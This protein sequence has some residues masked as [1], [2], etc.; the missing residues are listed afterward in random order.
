MENDDYVTPTEFPRL[1]GAKLITFDLETCDPNLMSQGP[2]AVRGDGFICG[3]SLATDNGFRGYFPMRHEEGGNM[4]P[5]M[6][7]RFAKDTLGDD[8]PKLGANI[9]YDIEWLKAEGVEVRGPKYDIQIADP[10]LDENHRSY[11]LDNIGARRLDRHKNEDLLMEA[12]AA[13]GWAPKEIKANMWRLHPR[14]VAPY[15]IEDSNLTYDIFMDQKPQ[16]EREGLWSVFNDIETPIVDVLVAMKF[17]GIRVDLE[18]ADRIACQLEQEEKTMQD[19][20]NLLVGTEVDVWSGQSIEFGAIKLGLEYPRTEKGNPSFEADWLYAHPHPYFA[21]IGKIRKLNRAGAVFIRNKII[22]LAHNGRIHARYRQ[23]RGDDKGTR[24]GRFS[25]EGPNMQQVPARDPYLAPLIRSI[26]IPEDGED[27]GGIDWSQQEPRLTVHYAYVR[28]YPGAAEARARYVD[29]PATD[30]HQLTADMVKQ[31]GG[32]EIDRTKQA[33]PI[34][35]G[36]AYGMGKAKLAAELGMTQR[37]SNV[38]LSAYHRAM[39]YVKMLGDDCAEIAKERGYIKTLLGRH[40]HFNLFGPTGWKP[41]VVPLRYEEAVREFEG[42]IV[43]YFTHKAFN[44]L[45]QGSAGDM[46]KKAMIDCF[47]EGHI[48]LL[49]MHDELAFSVKGL[50]MLR[51]INEIMLHCVKLEVPLKTDVEFGSSWGEAKKI[52]L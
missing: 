37:E 23:V 27:W 31:Y 22:G 44:A 4:L 24:S 35:L 18:K 30:Y 14:F 20:V 36:L 39:P 11:S 32:V 51:E 6:V 5:E 13:R 2:G 49:T 3:I 28:G 34:N 43:R 15:A 41:G 10:L 7:L 40:R 8:R 25:S 26:Y 33:K 29:D 46:V 19:E 50:P 52:I 17:K 38:I 1:D 48:P 21:G 47:R 45:V 16:L 12:G 9:G 42:Q